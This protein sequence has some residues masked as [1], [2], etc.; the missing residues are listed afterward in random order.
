M[1]EGLE[2]A[3]DMPHTISYAITY[4]NRINSFN[5]LPEDKRPPRDL[6]DK[7]YKLK[8]FLDE[9]FEV[10]G[11]NKSANYVEYNEEDIE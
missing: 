6:W 10:K 1:A 3:V 7:P 5:E 11:G 2:Y 4:R 9:V 8:D